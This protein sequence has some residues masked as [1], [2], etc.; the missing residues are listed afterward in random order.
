MTQLKRFSLFAV[1]LSLSL[2]I[3]SC[4]SGFEEMNIN[5][6]QADQ[7]DPNFKLTNIQLGIS[8][9]RYENWRTNLIYSSV[10]IQHLA[11]LPGY[12]SGDKYFYNSA[13]S[14]AMWDRYYPNIAK[15]IEDL[16]E[17]TAEDPE[18]VNMHHITQI[19]RIIMYHRLTDL[20]GDIPYSEAGRG[21]IDGI[22]HPK[23]DAQS[24]IY[25][26]ML[27][28]LEAATNA[29]NSGSPSF[30]GGDLIYQGD[31]EKWRKFANSLML[32][33]GMR[34]TEVDPGAAQSWVQKAIAGGT[35]E[36]NDDIAYVPHNDP[37]GWPNGNGQVFGADGNPRMS[38]FFVNWMKDH[39]DPR[40]FV[41]GQTPVA[42]ADPIGLPNGRITGGSD[43][44]IG[45]E[46][47]ASWV[48]C[49]SGATPCGMDIYMVPNDVITGTDDPM[50]FMTYA[51][52]EFLKAEAAVRGWYSGDA[53]T[54][55]TNG[56]RAA[57]EYLAM[58]G[59]A[60]AISSADID[61]Y[62]AANPYDPA[63][64]LKMISEQIWAAVLLNEYEAYANWRR[65]GYP[66]LTPTNHPR[67]VTGGTIPRRLRYRALEAVANPENYA[68]AIAA[69][70]PDELTT[71]IWWDK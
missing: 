21:F 55:Y 32:R 33:L 27:S 18:F 65:T 36:S 15:N 35:M 71:R 62:L 40:L 1:A 38:E 63:N 70:G 11:A 51:E 64:G 37:A 69:Q 19:V 59:A 16:L 41:Y 6:T 28:R 9:E 57:M 4:D 61:A 2:L 66:E 50:F 52:V 14:S 26:D 10:M 44:N 12:W 3:A 31:V 60:G 54:H 58:Y 67:N 8:G 34:L 5:P 17:Q 42:G 46:N 53:A 30:G 13:Y 48:S 24:F 20:Y 47:H 25:P 23:Y 39:N 45:I 49:D 56:V 22:T 43:P 7:I 68:A 29:F